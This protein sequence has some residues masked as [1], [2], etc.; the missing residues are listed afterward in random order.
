MYAETKETEDL[1]NRGMEK[2]VLLHFFAS[3]FTSKCSSHISQVA[4]GTGSMTAVGNQVWDHPR[5]LKEHKSQNTL[6]WMEALELWDAPM[7]SAELQM[8]LES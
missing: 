5:N 1:D 3:A 6:S 2:A 4:E 7:G 8:K